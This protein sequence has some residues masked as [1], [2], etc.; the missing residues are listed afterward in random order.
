MIT[1]FKQ[2]LDLLLT[3]RTTVTLSTHFTRQ[4][5]TLLAYDSLS[6]VV[7]SVE[8]VPV[9]PPSDFPLQPAINPINPL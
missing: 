3:V 6:L 5:F 1:Y 8:S 4:H 9:A 2:L 7:L